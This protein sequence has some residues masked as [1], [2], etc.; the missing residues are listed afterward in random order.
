MS[1]FGGEP[2]LS[3]GVFGFDL[4]L[5][6]FWK[7]EIQKKKQK[8][9]E[10]SHKWQIS[11]LCFWTLLYCLNNI[12]KVSWVVWSIW[13][14]SLVRNTADIQF[15]STPQNKIIWGHMEM[16]LTD[17][18]LSACF[19]PQEMANILAQKQ[20]RSIILTVSTCVLWAPCWGGR[21][22]WIYWSSVLAWFC[23]LFCDL[24]LWS[25]SGK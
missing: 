24:L 10:R 14:L 16:F 8:E 2:L 3:F 1:Y 25:S 13:A 21:V 7:E 17:A 5:T 22:W 18:C 4:V 20:L 11:F 15:W 9:K 19:L 6:F 23:G 12:H